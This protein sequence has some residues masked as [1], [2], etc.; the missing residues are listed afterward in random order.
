MRLCELL[1]ASALAFLLL[2]APVKA[3]LQAQTPVQSNALPQATLDYLRHSAHESPDWKL[4]EPHLP[5]PATA[6]VET[7]VIQADLLRVRRFPDDALE[8]YNYALD[9]GGDPAEI[10]NKIGITQM[11]LG[12]T[13]IARAYFQ[14]VVKLRRKDPQ[15]WNNLGAVEFMARNYPGAIQCYKRAI[16]LN[17]TYAVSHSN[18]GMAYVEQ[19]DFDSAKKELLIAMQLDPQIFTRTSSSGASLHMMNSSDRANFCFQMAKV[20]ARTGNEPEMLHQLQTAS[21]AGM[22]VQREMAQDG[23]L[24]RYVKDPRVAELVMV[25]KSLREGKLAR[26]NVATILPPAAPSAAPAASASAPAR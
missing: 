18:L 7:L 20:Y 10:F 25:A 11:E 21:E 4:I 2:P 15:A 23:D 1:S 6:S 8:Y 14:R 9:R 26:S 5:D 19:K 17:K 16:K 24:A 12:N 22:D 3:P 13:S